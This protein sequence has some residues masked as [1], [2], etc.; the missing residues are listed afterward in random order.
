MLTSIRDFRHGLHLRHI[1]VDFECL[2]SVWGALDEISVAH[3]GVR[4]SRRQALEIFRNGRGK[5]FSIYRERIYDEIAKKWILVY[6]V[7]KDCGNVAYKDFFE[8]VAVPEVKE[9]NEIFGFSRAS[10]EKTGDIIEFW[11]GVLDVANMA[12]GVVNVFNASV[13]PAEYLNGLEKALAQFTSTSRTTSTINDKRRGSFDCTLQTAEAERVM[14][15][16]HAIPGYE[17]L[18]N[19]CCLTEWEK[20]Q[21][22]SQ[23]RRKHNITGDDASMGADADAKPGDESSAHPGEEEADEPAND[24]TDVVRDSEIS[25]KQQLLDAL[26]KLFTVSED[27]NVCLYCGSTK[28]GHLECEHEKR[29]EVRKVLKAVRASLE[30]DSPASDDVDMEPPEHKK[31]GSGA[32]ERSGQTDEPTKP[33]FSEHQWYDSIR[34]MSE[35]GDLDEYGRFC[36]E[37]RDVTKLG[38]QNVVD[39]NEVIRDAIVRGGGD[40]W[41]VSEFL[42][43][44][45]DNNIR[46]PFYKRI[47]APQDGFLKIIPTTGAHFFNCFYFGG[48]EYAANYRFETGNRLDSYEDKVSTSLNRILRHNVGKASESQSLFCDDAGWVPIEEVLKCESIWR[49]EHARWPH[50]FLAP[51]GRAN[52]QSAWNVNEANYRM[53]LLFK[54]MFHCARYG[55]R[56]REQ[57]LAFGINKDIDRSSLT[58]IDNKVDADTHIPD[59]GL[60]LYPVAVRAPTGHKEGSS[61]DDVSLLSSLLSHPIAPNTIMS[62]PV[63][64]HITKKTN[65]RSIWRQGLIPGGLGEGHRMFTFFNPYVPWDHRS[66]T[67]TKSVDTRKGDYICLFIPTETL[68]VEYGGRLTDSG[69]I[70]SPKIIPFSAIKGGWIQDPK[71]QYN[72]TWLRLFVPSGDDQVVRSGTVK[73][74]TVA[75][76]ESILRVASQCIDAEDQPY[77]EITMD[78][79]NIVHQ[80]KNNLIEPGGREQYLA[81]IK[82][83]DYIVER[84]R[85]QTSGCRHCPHCL[86]ETPTKL[87]VCLVCWTELESCGIRPYRLQAPEDDEDEATKKELDEEV[88]RQEESLFKDTVHQA[89]EN[90]SESNDYGF[91]PD[92]VDYNEGDDEEMDQEEETQQE[93]DEIVEEEDDDEMDVEP[94]NEPSSKLPAWTKNLECGSKGMPGDGLVN[95]DVSEAA[96]HLYDNAVMSKIIAMFRLY[97]KQRVTL[98][99]EEYYTLMTETKRVRLD[100]DD[101]CPYT[102]EDQD[103]NLKRPT[104]LEL[105][106][107]FQEKGKKN[108]WSEGEKMYSGRPRNMM[109]PVIKTLEVYEKMMEFLVR[110]GYIPESLGFLMPMNRMQ[111]DA[112]GKHEMRVTISNFLRRL[113]KGTFPQN[114]NHTPSSVLGTTD[115]PTALNSQ[116]SRYI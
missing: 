100:L 76:K 71:D 47:E 105:D 17:S 28:H 83:I 54:I 11:L 23:Y 81:R 2:I 101:F 88:R 94:E 77:D 34:T 46:K 80:F 55:R 36:I 38:P 60:L 98:T 103:G 22:F 111:A 1:F 29:D 4:I 18:A 26:G 79:M 52:D 95:N 39:L 35:V 53:T 5:Q 8:K 70:V 51:K 43:N 59:E 9:R 7:T 48:V 58:C 37:G 32:T 93:D 114:M 110:A 82:L 31:D 50:V 97:Y 90:V 63:C 24:P 86:N 30:A 19:F 45:S 116:L 66:W 20:D 41:S 62:L 78:A 68:M 73:S 108:S 84:K 115:S 3:G 65:L 109:M 42:A 102:G 21:V 14:K 64:F 25:G 75:T 106:E 33:R 112:Q 40:T 99:P 96:A 27:V 44:Y 16:I 56:V 6:R 104:E 113:L 89:Q 91:N 69:Q 13:D 107:L 15:I 72:K 49:H 12:K 67:I 74:R 10:A 92:E 87:A 61:R 57:V 85:V